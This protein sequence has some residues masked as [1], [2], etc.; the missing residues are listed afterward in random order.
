MPRWRRG[1]VA[2]SPDPFADHPLPS[3]PIVRCP[4][5]GSGLIYPLACCHDGGATEIECHCPECEQTEVIVTSP[6][7]AAVWLLRD[8]RV[9]E[10]MSEL[11]DVLADEH[12]P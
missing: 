12:V 7:V 4:V 8:A 6:I 9:A 2:T 5:C 11:A 1:V 10:A 3:D